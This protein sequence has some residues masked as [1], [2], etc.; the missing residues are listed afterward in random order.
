MD[1]SRENYVRVCHLLLIAKCHTYATAR[2]FC[3]KHAFIK[4]AVEEGVDSA[5]DRDRITFSAVRTMRGDHSTTTTSI[6]G[7]VRIIEEDQTGYQTGHY[8]LR[9]S[10]Y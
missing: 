7:R 6:I 1:V 4:S 2:D 3:Q 8:N 9:Q 5:S 10:S